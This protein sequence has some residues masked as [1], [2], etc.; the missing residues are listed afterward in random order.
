[1]LAAVFFFSLPVRSQIAVV[2]GS[3]ARGESVFTDK[4]CI[5]CHAI[6]GQGGTRGPD[7]ARRSVRLYTPDLLASVMWNPAPEMWK[8]ISESGNTIPSLTSLETADLFSYFY[9]RLYFSVPGDAVRGRAVFVDRSC[10]NCHD[11]RSPG[12]GNKVGPPVST[13]NRVRDPIAWAE[14]MW[15]HSERMY[16]QMRQAS[17]PWPDLSTREMVDLLVY[18]QNL[19]TARSEQ[20]SFQPGEPELGRA[21]FESGCEGC[22]SFGE[23]LPN[24]IDLLERPG[25]RTL[26]GYATYMW[27]HAPQ[28]ASAATEGLPNLDDGAM[29]HL[30]AYLFAQ[31]YFFQRGDSAD[32]QRVYRSKNCVVCHEQERAETGAPD[33]TQSSEVYSPI[34]MTRSLWTHGPAMLLALEERNMAWPVFERTEMT[35]L[36]SYLNS[37]LLPRVAEAEEN[38]H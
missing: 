32:D 34:T 15:N 21:V 16:E 31:R 17:I 9:S 2:P 35:D 36:I 23:S 19:P 26:T 13:W 14:R 5:G 27:N 12:D 7:L 38:N 3:A 6:D 1:M 4:G 30:V 11:V 18:L 37:R 33:L 8:A 10:S 28:M 29:T 20:A 24:R 25:P 22:H